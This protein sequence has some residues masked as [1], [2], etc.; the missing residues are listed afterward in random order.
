MGV[1]T[2]KRNPPNPDTRR[3]PSVFP[4]PSMC[5]PENWHSVS[6]GPNSWSSRG[7]SSIFSSCP[8]FK[9][10]FKSCC[11]AHSLAFFS[12]STFCNHK[13][14]Y[15]KL[16]SFPTQH[17]KCYGTFCSLHN[18]NFNGCHL[19]ADHQIIYQYLMFFVVGLSHFHYF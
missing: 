17:G 12:P 14:L 13:I 16:C 1:I 7:I 19:Y 8:F 15:N 18:R 6:D 5:L 3:W 11:C 2:H 9:N 4:E 10:F